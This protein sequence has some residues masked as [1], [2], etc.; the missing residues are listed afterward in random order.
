[1][2]TGQATKADFFPVQAEMDQGP[3]FCNDIQ[4][5]RHLQSIDECRKDF[6]RVG[7]GGSCS[8]EWP[9][10]VHE[11]EQ[12]DQI[13]FAGN[14]ADIGG[15]YPENEPRLAGITLDWMARFISEEIR[16]DG[17]VPAQATTPCAGD[18]RGC[19]FALPGGAR[20]AGMR[21]KTKEAPPKH[22]FSLPLQY[23]NWP[24]VFCA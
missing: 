22:L 4:Y 19:A 16:E 11:P 3:A 14:H 10:R 21:I 8:V 17:R 7:W 13:W 6:K 2:R 1:L 20:P 12:F 24:I 9:D 15:S 18:A 5:A 23:R